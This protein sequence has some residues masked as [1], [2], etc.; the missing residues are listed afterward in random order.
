MPQDAAS[1]FKCNT[2]GE[3]SKLGGPYDRL[4][5][6]AKPETP[7]SDTQIFLSENSV[8]LLSI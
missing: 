5:S 1:K 2:K 6:Q 3:E 4:L 8:R 7:N